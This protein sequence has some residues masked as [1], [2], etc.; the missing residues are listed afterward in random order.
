MGDGRGNYLSSLT[1]EIEA[2]EQ[3]QW[4]LQGRSPPLRKNLGGPSFRRFVQKGWGC[5][6]FLD[7]AL[8]THLQAI[9]TTAL[10]LSLDKQTCAAVLFS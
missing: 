4:V 2:R 1:M 6:L 7:P 8:Q 3:V 9:Q 10:N 5:F